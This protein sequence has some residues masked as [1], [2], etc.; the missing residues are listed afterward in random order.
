MKFLIP[1]TSWTCQAK[2]DGVLVMLSA[3]P[4]P[5][6]SMCPDTAP[7]LALLQED[8]WALEMSIDGFQLYVLALWGP[9]SAPFFFWGTTY[10]WACKVTDRQERPI[11]CTWDV[12]SQ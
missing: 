7:L 11:L 10:P 6:A 3:L 5:L 12:G 2:T 1:P 9:S 8:Y 4:K